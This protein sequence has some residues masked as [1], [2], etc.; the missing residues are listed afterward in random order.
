MRK[1]DEKKTSPDAVT[2]KVI[3]ELGAEV[4]KI[5]TEL[6]AAKKGVDR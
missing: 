6:P 3:R 5:K 1:E 2:R 4:Q